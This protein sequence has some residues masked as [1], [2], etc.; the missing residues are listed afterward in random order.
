[1]KICA[2]DS[3]LP[4][5]LAACAVAL[6]VPAAGCGGDGSAPT[7]EVLSAT[8]L[9]IDPARD[10]A[11]DLTLRVAY[12]DPDGDLGRGVAEVHDCRAEGLLTR[13]ELP[14]IASNEAVD[15]GVAIEGELTLVVADIGAAEA[16][17]DPPEICRELGVGAPQGSAQAFCVV[18][19]DEAGNTGAGDCTEPIQVLPESL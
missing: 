15:E 17:P 4:R 12:A 3:L 11:D 2:S 10:E 18:L 1:V 13:L 16:A 9:E 14:G 8:P 5:V 7:V 19:V 6:S